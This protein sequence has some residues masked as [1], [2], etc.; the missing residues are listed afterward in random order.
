[1]RH[2]NSGNI[3]L[4]VDILCTSPQGKN[5]H[6]LHRVDIRQY[7]HVFSSESEENHIFHEALRTPLEHRDNNFKV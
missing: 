5:V 1:M 3:W 2:L 4:N 7:P 6:K